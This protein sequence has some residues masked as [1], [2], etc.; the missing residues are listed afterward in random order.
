MG[1]VVGISTDVSEG[2]RTVV[3]SLSEARN[4]ARHGFDA[5]ENQFSGRLAD[6]LGDRQFDE[7]ILEQD[8]ANGILWYYMNPQER[9]CATTG[10]M[11]DIRSMQA[12]V[13]QA[14]ADRTADDPMP[15]RYLVLASA[16]P[17]IFNLG[18]NL[19]LFA[20][21][22]ERKDRKA[23][24]D[25]AR[26]AIDVIHTNSINLDLPL[27]TISLVQGDALGGGFE[28]ALCSNFII[29][30]RGAKF[31]LPEI[32]FGLF[33]GM[34]AYTF[35]ARRIGVAEA[36]RMIFSGKIYGAE[37]LHDM[38]VVDLVTD[39]DFGK[40]AVRNYVREIESRRQVHRAIYEARS[41][42]NPVPRKEMDDIGLVWVETA[43]SLD[44]A[45]I[46]KMRRLAN[47]QERRSRR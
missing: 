40:E 13:R 38:G 8:T 4:A 9:P 47:A 23:L 3:P 32:L 14:F 42:V 2:A 45:D 12:G 20:D 26:L 31:G 16:I 18:G 44:E 24:E 41:I 10:L 11:E 17:G 22:I 35:L 21:L 46:R 25:Y 30:E 7:L 29:A 34:G 43:L 37:E 27:T 33:P 39:N 36:E 28:A 6:H 1:N 15:T 5:A 19:T